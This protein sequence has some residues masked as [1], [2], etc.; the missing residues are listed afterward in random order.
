MARKV[1][2]FGYNQIPALKQ[3]DTVYKGRRK[4]DQDPVG[5]DDPEYCS[6]YYSDTFVNKTHRG[7]LEISC[8]APEK[9]YS[10]K[11]DFAGNHEITTN[12]GSKITGT[13]GTRADFNKQGSM[14]MTQGAT[15]LMNYN[16]IRQLVGNLGDNPALA[17]LPKG[18]GFYRENSGKDCVL[19]E[20]QTKAVFGAS[21]KGTY[22]LGKHTINAEDGVG[23]GVNKGPNKNV[24]TRWEAN[25]TFHVQVKP[26]GE[27]GGNAVVKIDP[28]G[29]IT[30]TS[31]GTIYMQSASDTTIEA[32]TLNIKANVKLEGDM[33]QNGVH[34]DNKGTHC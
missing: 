19:C 23:I 24:W 33:Q 22:C 31:A 3:P 5:P 12:S 32:P 18:G 17:H 4:T 8:Y 6:D 15:Q 29:N 11:W 10:E 2:E 27:E 9:C 34:T 13:T 14:S 1:D 20:N 30:I 28:N 25:G 7:D 16:M 26:Q 21:G